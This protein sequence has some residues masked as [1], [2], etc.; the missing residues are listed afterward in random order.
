MNKGQKN[1]GGEKSGIVRHGAEIHVKKYYAIGS[2]NRGGGGG[3]S[4]EPGGEKNA[5][6]VRENN[7]NNSGTSGGNPERGG[8]SKVF[9]G[10][11]RTTG[12]PESTKN[13]V[14]ADRRSLGY[15]LGGRSSN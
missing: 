4:N 1:C 2:C 10:G 5:F 3:G 9:L 11:P 15:C 8:G 7:R 12:G 6:G 14:L 13:Y